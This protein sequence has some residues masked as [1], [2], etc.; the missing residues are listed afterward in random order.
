MKYITIR[1]VFFFLTLP[2]F[3]LGQ[4]HDYVW[5]FGY[6]SNA[7]LEYPGIEG[8]RLDF[9]ESP[10][11]VDYAPV[12]GNINVS[13]ATISDENGNLLF[14]TNGCAIYKADHE[15]MENGSGL[16]PGNVSIEWCGKDG[17]GYIA[18]VQSC[19]VLPHPGESNKYVLFH[20]HLLLQYEPFFD[21]ISDSLLYT[22]VDMSLSNNEG[23]VIEK[24]T[25]II[26]E[27]LT[28]GQVTAVKHANGKDWWIITAGDQ[29]NQY[30]KVLLNELGVT[31]HDI[32][33]IGISSSF[34]GAAGGQ[35]AFSPD[36]RK[37]ARYSSPDGLFLFDF[38]RQSGQ[39]SNFQHI[40]IEN[41]GI[42]DGV[43]F[44][45][46]SRFLYVSAEDSLFQFDMKVPD[47]INSQILIG[48]FDGYESPFPT[49][50][51]NAQLAPDCK[52]YINSL[53]TVDVL[54]VIHNPDEPGQACNFEQHAVQLPFN[55]LRSLPHFPN[56]RLGPLVEGENPPP[57]CEPVVSTEEEVPLSLQKAY[58]FP[59]PA[60]GYFKVVFEEA[61]RRP[62]RVVLYNGLGQVVLEEVLGV[63]SREFRL[64]VGGVP[65]G[66]YFYSIF[67]EGEVVKGGKLVVAGGR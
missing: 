11:T 15:I 29:S 22:L 38:D 54:H 12:G 23:V 25:P 37:Y 33:N 2:L 47:I 60:P 8:V 5:M 19:L 56:Y 32:Q 3:C 10:P 40:P 39:L 57:P 7:T 16:N 51:F 28:Y 49:T 30:F 41:E 36:G 35:V 26:E 31:L 44:S 24:N 53:T 27:P 48:V 66:L 34:N 52:I 45:P 67:R 18:G 46:N 64:E 63:G 17:Y 61:L 59:N 21:A 65:S 43:A 50:F 55:H 13:N 62:G 58:V 9:N 6:N 20:K 42:A 1:C 14:Y 4:K